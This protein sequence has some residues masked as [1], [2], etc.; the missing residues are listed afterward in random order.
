MHKKMIAGIASSD[1]QFVP[2]PLLCFFL[3]PTTRELTS[4]FLF[5]FSAFGVAAAIVA[6]WSWDRL[7][8]CHGDVMETGGKNA[9]TSTLGDL[10]AAA[11]KK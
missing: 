3:C 9:W 1:K 4:P 10:I 6:G 7:I 11:Q 5:S 8:P 2:S